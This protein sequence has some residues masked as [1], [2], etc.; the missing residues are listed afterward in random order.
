MSKDPGGNHFVLVFRHRERNKMRLDLFR[1]TGSGIIF[2]LPHH[3]SP[4]LILCIGPP[5]EKWNF[6][7]PHQCLDARRDGDTFLCL[8][9]NELPEK[10]S[11]PLPIEME[12][13]PGDS[14]R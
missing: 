14:T 11:I 12:V 13:L 10:F 4:P 1:E 5:R 8:L 2:S 3:R 6:I 7:L 9:E